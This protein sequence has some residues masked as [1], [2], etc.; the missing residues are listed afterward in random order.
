MRNVGSAY[1]EHLACE[2]FCILQVF[3]A[4]PAPV[5]KQEF[6]RAMIPSKDRGILHYRDHLF[7]TLGFYGRAE[8]CDP[9]TGK[10]IVCLPSRSFSGILRKRSDLF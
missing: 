9:A 4:G 3:R 10:I 1:L 8:Q 2:L 7:G 5:K 6:T